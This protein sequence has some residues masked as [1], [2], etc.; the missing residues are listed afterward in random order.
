MPSMTTRNGSRPRREGSH[1]CSREFCSPP[2]WPARP[3]PGRRRC[4]PC[5]RSACGTRSRP[6]PDAWWPAPRCRPGWRQHPCPRPSAA[7]GP[8][9]GWRSAAPAR[10]G[11]PPPARRRVPG[12]PGA[13]SA[14]VRPD[15]HPSGPVVRPAPTRSARPRR[16]APFPRAR[17]GPIPP[18]RTPARPPLP[19]LPPDGAPL[20]SRPPPRPR[21]GGVIGPPPPSAVRP[22]R[23]AR[24][25]GRRPCRRRPRPGPAHPVPRPGSP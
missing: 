2:A 7:S 5:R 24:T 13:A 12:S 1:N 17:P 10:P 4:G 22:A 8:F 19:R 15:R 25:R 9:A 21:P 20:P 23:P 18:G 14:P 11:G 3:R 6:G 16:C